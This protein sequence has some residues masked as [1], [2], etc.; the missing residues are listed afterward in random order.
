MKTKIAMIAFMAISF[1][2]TG[3]VVRDTRAENTPPSGYN[4]EVK[5]DFKAREA[6]G[7]PGFGT[8]SGM[9]TFAPW[10]D[11]SGGHHH[12]LNF[13]AGGIYYR[14]GLASA[15]TWGNWSKILTSN[16]DIVLEGI[17]GA[18]L[19]RGIYPFKMH[20]SYSDDGTGYGPAWIHTN[21]RGTTHPTMFLQTSGNSANLRVNDA[22]GLGPMTVELGKY[23]VVDTNTWVS[24]AVG[25][26]SYFNNGGNVGIG[27][28]TPDSK[29]AV[30]G[31]IHSKEVKVDLVGWPDFVFEESYNLPTLKEVEDHIK[32]KGHLKNI[33]SVKEVV[34]NGVLLGEMNKNLL[35]KIEELTLYT[36]QQEKEI[37]KL[38]EKNKEIKSLSER[39]AKLEKLL[40]K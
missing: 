32:R 19:K 14:N 24:G 38:K 27:T 22:I 26:N 29:L 5:Y 39:L 30:N 9:M 8:Y 2:V 21:T 13:N 11:N 31:T 37:E 17:Y 4:R 18:E 20:W 36:I 28:R 25:E 3:Q 35:Q 23:P 10:V 40:E 7:V 12:Q 6:V 1:V 15:T 16:S 33:P 34:K